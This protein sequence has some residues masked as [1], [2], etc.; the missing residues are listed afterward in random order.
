MRRRPPRSTLTYTLFPYTTL[1]RSN[2][3]LEFRGSAVRRYNNQAIVKPD[4]SY[5]ISKL[6]EDVKFKY[7]NLKEPAKLD[8]KGIFAYYM[9]EVVSPPRVAGQ[10]TL[11]QE[12]AG[13]AGNTRVAYLYSP[14]LGR[15]NRA[16][17]VGYDKDRKSTRLNS[18]H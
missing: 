12:T 14:G 15:V 11:V 5:K 6:I 17:D 10:I 13:G 9:Q 1:F 8:K 2:H 4:G 18:S 7:A 16:P 3:K